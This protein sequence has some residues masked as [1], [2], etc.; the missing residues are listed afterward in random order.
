MIAKLLVFLETGDEHYSR[1]EFEAACKEAK[2]FAAVPR[3]LTRCK[4]LL[5]EFGS[6]FAPK[7]ECEASVFYK[8]SL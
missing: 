7:K 3:V 5:V 1:Q 2:T 4:Q 8:G 6:N